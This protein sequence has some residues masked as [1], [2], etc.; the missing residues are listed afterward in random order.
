M[1]IS[2]TELTDALNKLNLKAEYLMSGGGCGTIYIGEPDAEGY[3]PYAV[4]P[5]NYYDA[6]ADL[7]EMGWGADD[8]SGSAPFHQTS[9]PISVATL[10][11][12]I[13]S[14]Y[15]NETKGN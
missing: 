12:V 15:H 4:G 14:N 7:A 8:K 3:Y 11:D 10:A 6:T 1:T 2:M 9:G 13:L 5:S